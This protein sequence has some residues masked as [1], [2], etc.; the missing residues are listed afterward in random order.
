MKQGI[1]PRRPSE[2]L[3]QRRFAAPRAG[4]TLIELLVVISTTPVLIGLLLPAVQSARESAARA[5]C[6]NNLKQL[7]IAA[8]NYESTNRK[9]PPTL[10]DAMH[11]AGLP[12]SGM[13]D[14]FWASS[15]RADANGW[16]VVMNPVPGVTGSETAYVRGGR[17]G[18]IAI[19]WQPTPGAREGA[20]QMWQKVR[21]TAATH[22]TTVLAW[23]RVS[24]S[25][26]L[27]KLPVN[28]PLA[29]QQAT[30]MFKSP[31]GTVGFG[32]IR[33]GLQAQLGDGSVR[34]IRE[35]LW[36]SIQEAMQLGAYGERWDT[37]AGAPVP[38][39]GSFNMFSLGFLKE[40]TRTLV[41]DSRLAQSL[42]VHLD[43]AEAAERTGDQLTREA[44]MKAY[45]E[46]VN[47]AAERPLPLMSPL[48]AQTL[49]GLSD[50]EYKYV[51]VRR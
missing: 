15:Y 25:S 28:D 29:L 22:A 8:H 35:S 1:L 43:R 47:A 4:F 7:A 2:G 40:T 44:A 31:D 32:S 38:S 49:M 12:G 9:F 3:T 23:A 17:N 30:D 13:T 21:S 39:V 50:P 42:I 37:L 36:R 5:R 51:P 20:E 16:S 33:S 48:N 10:A 6:T 11:A 24:D 27:P 46:A 41:T 14:G 34:G 26:A 19:D 45:V 18:Q